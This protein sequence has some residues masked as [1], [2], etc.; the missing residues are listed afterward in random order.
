[1]LSLGGAEMAKV[2]FHL[3][4][5]KGSAASFSKTVITCPWYWTAMSMY[6]L[7]CGSYITAG[8][9][10]WLHNSGSLLFCA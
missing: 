9:G 10:L 4:L 3:P 6:I 2:F 1:M 8:L 5:L 7:D